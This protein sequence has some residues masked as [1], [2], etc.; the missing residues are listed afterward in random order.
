[1]SMVSDNTREFLFPNSIETNFKAEVFAALLIEAGFDLEQIVMVRDGNSRSNISK[2]ID[3]VE[4]RSSV[5]GSETSYIQIKTNRRSIYDSLPEGLFHTSVFPDK[6]K[7]KER[8]LEEIKQHRNEEFFIRRFFR[9]F[10]NEVDRDAIQSQLIELRYDK[11]NRYRAYTDIFAAYWPI[12]TAMPTHNALL[13]V[14]IIPH[15]HLIRN[16]MKDLSSALSLLLDAPVHVTLQ[17]KKQ[18]I[19]AEKP[20]RLGNMTLGINSV[21]VGKFYDGEKDVHIHIGDIPACDVERFLPGNNFH[22]I[23]MTLADIF[24][25][26]DKIFDISVSVIP[27]QRKAC[28]KSTINAYPCYLGINTYL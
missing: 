23:L 25:G 5:T 4:Q 28:L 21:N 1:M 22:R 6:V 27:A 20:N 14:Q 2:D 24:L 17:T 8:I 12:I 15:I 3:S 11:K 26:A 16:N 18:R 7:D 9:L 19:K 13:F 10:E